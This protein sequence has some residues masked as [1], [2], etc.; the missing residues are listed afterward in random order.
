MNDEVMRGQEADDGLRNVSS[1]GEGGQASQID[2]TADAQQVLEGLSPR[3]TIKDGPDLIVI[4][5][6]SG[7]GRTE[8]MHTFEDLGYFCID[9]LPPSLLTN[10]VSLAGLPSGSLRKLAVVCDLRTKEFFP[11]LTSELH[12]LADCGLTYSVLF[13]DSTDDALLRRFKTSRRRHP[14]CDG[15]MTIIAGIKK[16][17]HLL[18]EAQEI[19]NFV[20]DTTDVRPQD[21]RA[22]IRTL[23]SG[24]TLKEGMGVA[25][26]S[27][28]FKH[29]APA[30]AD[31]VIDVR[32]LPNPFYEPELRTLTGLDAAVRDYVLGKP[33]TDDFLDAWHHL[34]DIVMPGYVTEGKQ[35]LSIGVGCTGGQHRSVVLAEETGAYLTSK[36]YYVATSHRDIALAEVM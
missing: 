36:G 15:G 10:L 32:F 27:F 23:F 34:L 18:T 25:V 29:G 31:I 35:H 33:E 4:T 8:A 26:F 17:R 20:I 19:A 2:V 28:G 30:D 21:L 9:N 7:A 1:G 16:E 3:D 5:G 12:R 24:Q 6:M 14:L 11:E 22:R 13:L